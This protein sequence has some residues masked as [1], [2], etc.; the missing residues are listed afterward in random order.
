MV[1]LKKINSE[2]YGDLWFQINLTIL[3]WSTLRSMWKQYLKCREI[4]EMIQK[5][6]SKG[7]MRWE[8]NVKWVQESTNMQLSFVKIA[9]TS[10]SKRRVVV[11]VVIVEVNKD[12]LLEQCR[13]TKRRKG[14]FFFFCQKSPVIIFIFYTIYNNI[15]YLFKDSS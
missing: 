4:Q 6:Y 14:L 11:V 3:C 5:S 9:Y 1:L 12:V 13:H 2:I 10:T 8:L 15:D 7:G